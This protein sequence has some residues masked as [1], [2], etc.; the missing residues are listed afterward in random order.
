MAKNQPGAG[1]ELYEKVKRLFLEAK[2]EE[3][4]TLLDEEKLRQLDEEAKKAIENAVQPR[5]L[6]A[7]LFTVRLRFDEAEKSYLQAIEIAPDNFIA[8]FAFAYFNHGLNR[9][10]QAKTAYSR[11]LELARKSENKAELAETLNN[12]GILDNDQNGMDEAR[13]E[14]QE[15]L[16]IYHELSQKDPEDYLADVAT[17]LNNLGILDAIRTE[18][19]SPRRNIMRHYKFAVS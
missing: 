6:K 11:C 15:A 3:A 10:Q 16:Q 17:T 4:I 12:L 1:S 2:V 7:Q 18:R 13:R 19:R 8:S 5:L 14:Y 9:Y